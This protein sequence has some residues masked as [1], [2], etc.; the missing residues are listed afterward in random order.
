[1]DP[2]IRRTADLRAAGYDRDELRRMVRSGAL[3]PVRRGAYVIASPDDADALYL[4]AVRAAVLALAEGAV[5]SHVSAA[6]LHGLPLW[7]LRRTRAHVT[8]PGGTGGRCGTHVHVHT[9]PLGADE[10]VT[11]DGLVVTCRART[12]ADLARTAGFASAV[13][14]ADAALHAGLDRSAL[15]AALERARGWPGVPAA[16]RVVGFADSRS[17][18]VGESRSRVAIAATGLPA[19][20]LQWPVRHGD[21]TAR[22]DFAW[23]ALR[24]VGEFDGRVKYGRLLRPGRQPATSS[25]PRSC[26]RTPSARRGGRWSA[27]PGPTSATSVR[28]PRGSASGSG[29]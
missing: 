28:R 27:G 9:A 2:L 18:S 5:V 16:R 19:P 21:G 23:P 22:T 1:V 3:V 15:D 6:A 8:Y 26:A 13:A 10:T 25:T 20:E 17:E 14:T 24:T 29:V 11:L 4:L 12:V 7:G